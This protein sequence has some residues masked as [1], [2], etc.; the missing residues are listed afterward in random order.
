MTHYN[1]LTTSKIYDCIQKYTHKKSSGFSIFVKGLAFLII[2]Y[3]AFTSI[4]TKNG[5][6]EIKL[7]K[8]TVNTVEDF[9]CFDDAHNIM[10]YA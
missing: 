3:D 9:V 4:T 10:C 7:T 8:K 1:E 6:L 5:I 2:R